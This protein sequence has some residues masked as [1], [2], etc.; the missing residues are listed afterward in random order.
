MI[1]GNI[2]SFA[3]EYELDKNY[4]EEWL[5][6][7]LC[8]W[9]DGVRVGAY[10]LGTSMRDALFQ[11]K[12]ILH[13]CRNRFGASLCELDAK[14]RFYAIDNALY[15]DIEENYI[16]LE[17]PIRYDVRIPIDIFDQWKIYLV[18]CKN[19]AMLIF[20]EIDNEQIN[21]YYLSI[22]KFDQIIRNFHD[23]L[24]ADYNKEVS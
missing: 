1:F 24:E 2:N 18:E 6:G 16:Q 20:K 11:M 21:S 7:K 23:Q 22:G 3:I 12:Y 5:F 14:E 15:G 17:N 19:N 4:G 9:I 8:Y 13:Y 10:D